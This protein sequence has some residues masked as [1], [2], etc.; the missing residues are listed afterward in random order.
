MAVGG[1][2]RH[3]V[4]LL[5]ENNY[6][7]W[8]ERVKAYL[9]QR[10]L[11][12]AINDE[13]PEDVGI[14]TPRQHNKNQDALYFMKTVV[15]DA[16]LNDIRFCTT[17]R[18]A[19]E[20]IKE[21]HCNVGLMHL[22]TVLEELCT[23]KK[24]DDVSMR[25]YMDKIENWC[26]QLAEGGMPFTEK[27]VAAFMLRSLPREKY[28]ILVRSLEQNEEAINVRNVKS[29]LLLEE[30]R[31]KLEKEVAESEV[32]ALNARKHV[33]GQS[34]EKGNGKKYGGNLR[35]RDSGSHVSDSR[36]DL[37]CYN[38]GTWGHISKQCK[39]SR[40]DNS[41]KCYS[42][43]KLGHTSSNCRER[44]A[45]E[46]SR[47]ATVKK[48]EENK[49]EDKGD[50]NKFR[51]C[52]AGRA[53]FSKSDQTLWVL[54]SGS[55]DHMT[56][57]RSAFV[58][59]KELNG[60]VGL[61]KGEVAVKGIGSV[62]ITMTDECG[63]WTLGLSD[64]LYVPDL[65]YNLLSVKCLANKGINTRFDSNGAVGVDADTEEMTSVFCAEESGGIYLLRTVRQHEP[66]NAVATKKQQQDQGV[67]DAVALRA[68]TVW[69]ER[70]GH[71]HETALAKVPG[72][73]IPKSTNSS[74]NVRCEVCITGKMTKI[75]F[76]KKSNRCTMKPLELIHSDL[77]GEIRPCS[78]GGAQYVLTLIDDFS[79][80][81]TVR[82]LVRKS[83][84]LK[85]FVLFKSEVE[86]M[87]DVKIKAIQSDGGGEYCNKAFENSLQANGIVHRKT[88]PRCPQQN[89]VAERQNRTLAEMA[90]C[91]LIQSCAPTYL[92]AEAVNTACFIRNLCP[93]KAISD[94]IP[95][96]VWSGEKVTK[97]LL[98]RI[99]VFGCRVWVRVEPKGKFGQRAIEGVF[100]GYE[101]HRKGYRVWMLT[102][103]K[104][105]I[106]YHV[107]FE[108][109]IF[110]FRHLDT[111]HV[112]ND[113]NNEMF[114]LL[115]KYE[116]VVVSDDEISVE[117]DAEVSN[118]A[119]RED[120]RLDESNV[121]TLQD[122]GEH[123]NFV[124]VGKNEN[125]DTDIVVLDSSI[126]DT[127]TSNH[128]INTV[129]GAEDTTGVTVDANVHLPRRSTRVP[130]ITKCTCCNICRCLENSSKEGTV[131]RPERSSKA[132]NKCICCNASRCE[133][134]DIN[135]P[136]DVHDAL[137][138]EH[139]HLW[140]QAMGSEIQSLKVQK[141]WT[142]VKRPSDKNVIGCK[143]VLKV[144]R[145]PNGEIER[146]KARLVAR[147]FAQ[148]PGVD[149]HETYSPVVKLRSI[150]ILMALG[151]ENNWDHEFL[152]V[153]CAYLNSRL[154]EEIYM[155]QPQYF[156]EHNRDRN[157][158]VCKLNKG[159]YGLKQA[160]R[161]WFN[162]ITNLLVGLGLKPCISDPC[163]YT[164]EGKE[165]IVALYVDD[166]GVWGSECKIDWFKG[167]LSKLLDIRILNDS[168]FLSIRVT[169][170]NGDTIALD[171][172][173]YITQ[174]LEQFGMEN[175][176]GLSTP[177]EISKS[178]SIPGE[179]VQFNENTY[180]QAVGSLL[181]LSGGTRPDIAF[182][183]NKLSRKCNEP[184]MS[185]W[186]DVQHVLRY[187][188][189]TIDLKLC[190]YKTGSPIEVYC[191][192]DFG[193]DKV[194]RKSC[195]GYV[196]LLAGTA[197]SWHSKK[198]SVVAQ[199]TVE[200][201]FIAMAEVTKEIAWIRNLLC[202][203]SQS[204]YVSTPCIVQ[205][206]N[207]GA[208]SQVS[209][210]VMS[211][212]AKHIDLKFHYVRECVKENVVKFHY[213]P[214]NQNLADL[215]TKILNGVKTKI[216]ARKL[217][218]IYL[219]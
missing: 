168:Q 113:T 126:R 93:S 169:K 50:Q 117:S 80:F 87:H 133:L 90:R 33:Q 106:A 20:L 143:W 97:E 18:E 47:M 140:L 67:R 124:N 146:L 30:K 102:E 73:P 57:L 204:K 123:P 155:E 200:A 84:T 61:G 189:K 15:D 196:V 206:D 64:V 163:I 16:S 184:K 23:Y 74:E 101:S 94:K 100:L 118:D 202:E 125:V 139:K 177:L 152:D 98:Q 131:D 1:R 43:G 153:Q 174:V 161:E 165:I 28:E 127:D 96:E 192:A 171:Q 85:E 216:V 58:T 209:N 164:D 111:K 138:S 77:M 207:Q 213:V 197:V 69:H 120:K 70:F 119:V 39:S 115:D 211:E 121:D 99:K 103:R 167:E 214:S 156:E 4:P 185:D 203:L 215:F 11:L 170:P 92:W 91:M 9:G 150:R 10:R 208:I 154:E 25:E 160:G 219:S 13:F 31:L 137:N 2:E 44:K 63:G 48:D 194:D 81:V 12:E 145:Y 148:I 53:L 17:A 76:P 52:I 181:Y 29:K 86:N 83:D 183:V 142:I 5:T 186:R 176:K 205:C 191:D 147:G 175:A 212:K 193:N 166:I 22:V 89:G 112:V 172:S 51:G 71:L 218:L 54:D 162:H 72:L 68:A 105:K 198:Q 151:I 132:S 35:T 107:I 59:F 122:A 37:K 201:E 157:I 130:K 129:D 62:H 136:V 32:R 141:V 7:Y 180:R 24:R 95:W 79:R 82:F 42:C 34:R 144:K 27:T 190:Y 6:T 66:R 26:F 158:F 195:S 182:A 149:F 14:W 159:L 8:S 108:E 46:A 65:E 45:Y 56:P 3:I 217:G 134:T 36:L 49:D 55:S 187:L 135:N 21:I 38:C 41:V 75:P 116:T 128:M 110:P 104:V 114:I 210:H 78:V 40:V 60:S 188:K 179:E 178:G 109:N 19:W 199:S 88:V 173:H